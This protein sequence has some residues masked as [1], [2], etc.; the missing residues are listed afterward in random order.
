MTNRFQDQITSARRNTSTRIDLYPHT[1]EETIAAVT[2][3]AAANGDGTDPDA[4]EWVFIV[5]TKE[6]TVDLCRR[7]LHLEHLEALAAIDH[8]RL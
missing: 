1:I 8:I 5:V 3:A 6:A 2:A 7:I 4:E